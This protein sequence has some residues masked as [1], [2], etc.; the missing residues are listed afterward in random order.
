MEREIQEEVEGLKKTV[1]GLSAQLQYYRSAL[2]S[3]FGYIVKYEERLE[4]KERQQVLEEWYA[5]LNRTYA[6]HLAHIRAQDPD[7][8]SRL[9]LR[10]LEPELFMP[11]PDE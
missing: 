9:D 5:T 10:E 4:G 7:L 11:P 3:L 1:R 8:A 2:T 6:D